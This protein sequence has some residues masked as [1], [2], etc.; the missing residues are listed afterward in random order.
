VIYR[1]DQECG[2]GGDLLQG[3]LQG[4]ELALAPVLIYYE[5]CRCGDVGEDLI[6]V[7]AEDYDR[8]I[9]GRAIFDGD[10]QRG[11][12]A[13]RGQGFG[14]GQGWRRSGGQ[15]DGDDFLWWANGHEGERKDNT[16]SGGFRLK[17]MRGKTGRV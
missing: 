11:F 17:G 16:G 15:D 6:G 12:F 9:Y 1:V 7:G 14:E 8:L 4:G 10:G 5:F 3:G 13:E 2:V